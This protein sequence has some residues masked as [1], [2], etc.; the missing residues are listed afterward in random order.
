VI[1][2]PVPAPGTIPDHVLVNET[3]ETIGYGHPFVLEQRTNDGW[4]HVR[5]RCA[6]T[7]EGL[8]RETRRRLGGVRRYRSVLVPESGRDA[9]GNGRRRLRD[10]YM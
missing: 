8:S 5:N 1:V 7:L 9:D 2:P 4:R 3:E 10:S 6:F